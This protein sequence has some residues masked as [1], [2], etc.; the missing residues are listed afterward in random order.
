[1]F[2]ALIVMF[3]RLKSLIRKQV[4]G[5]MNSA[6]RLPGPQHGLV[7]QKITELGPWF[8][9]FQLA[10]DLW[11]N[12]S[13]SG[14]GADY[15]DWRWR[16]V[17]TLLPDVAG[18]T[19]LDVGCSS[20]FFSLKLKELGAAYV[21]GVDAGE[22][23]KAI[24]QARFAAR[25][26]SLDVDFR[27]LSVYDLREIGRQFDLIL[28]M[29]VLY[30]LR[31]PLLALEAVR[32]VCGETLI[33]QTITTPH[34]R[35]LNEIDSASLQKAGLRSPVLTEDRFPAVRFIEGPLDFDVTCWFIPNPQAVVSMLRSC[36]FRP[37]ETLFPREHEMIVRCS[38]VREN[39]LLK[40]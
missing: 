25:T 31:H 3:G 15:P 12:S 18:K 1:V 20:G 19:V 28:F 40:G 17:R 38:T 36:S 26:L 13:G 8:H 24:E 21:L 39:G 34:D 27:V 29:G 22:Q 32:S 33:L 5:A 16:H 2:Q 35:T 9:N 6:R 37:N 14:P 23:P 10:A 7:Q 11:T 4:Y 30:H